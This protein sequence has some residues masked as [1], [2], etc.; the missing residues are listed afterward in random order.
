MTAIPAKGYIAGG[1]EEFL[2]PGAGDPKPPTGVKV[3]LLTEGMIA[4]HGVWRD[5]GS[6]IGWARLPR[7]NRDKEAQL[8]DKH[9][10]AR[11]DDAQGQQ[12]VRECSGD[13]TEQAQG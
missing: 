5:D 1:A 2:Y 9:A 4:T 3:C 8:G 11:Q 12:P 7:R 13:G 10:V 6:V